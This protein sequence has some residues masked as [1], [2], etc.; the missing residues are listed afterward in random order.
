MKMQ[1]VRNIAKK[2][3]INIGPSRTKQDLIRD[4]QITEGNSPCYKTISDC[5]IM[6]CLWR[7]DCLSKKK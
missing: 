2:M 5:G 3:N 1:E 6:N 4:I 7:S